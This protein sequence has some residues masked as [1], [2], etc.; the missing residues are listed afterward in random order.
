MLPDMFVPAF[1]VMGAPGPS[2]A[3]P[4]VES[5]FAT[6]QQR[7]IGKEIS[8]WNKKGGRRRMYICG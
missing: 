7:V 5:I 4:L 1:C 6:V 8:S 2:M 3:V